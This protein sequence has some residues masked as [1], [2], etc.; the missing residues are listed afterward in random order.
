[1]QMGH[2]LVERR[3]SDILDKVAALSCIV[4]AVVHDFRCEICRITYDNTLT[5]YYYRHPGLSNNYFMATSHP[6]AIRY[7]DD[8]ILEN[9]HVSEAFMV[10]F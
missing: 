1:M 9:Y 3:I 5:F 8:S 7:N 6:L 10:R 2:F 4:A